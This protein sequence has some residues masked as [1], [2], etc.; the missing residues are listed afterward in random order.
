MVRPPRLDEVEVVICSEDREISGQLRQVAIDPISGVFLVAFG[1]NARDLEGRLAL[2][3]SLM[4][5]DDDSVLGT[6]VFDVLQSFTFIPLSRPKP[7]T[8]R[9]YGEAFRKAILKAVERHE[10]INESL[11][12]CEGCILRGIAN[13]PTEGKAYC[14]MFR[15]KPDLAGEC[16]HYYA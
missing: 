13:A 5:L 8:M 15:E 10:D 9:T 6:T 14:Y 11:P 3:N 4:R 12:G 7:E 2:V 1:E 16:P